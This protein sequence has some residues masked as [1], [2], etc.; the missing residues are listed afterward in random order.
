MLY[1]AFFDISDPTLGLGQVIVGD[2]T[3]SNVIIEFATLLGFDADA[4]VTPKLMHSPIAE[5]SIQAQDGSAT[6]VS[7]KLSRQSFG[8]AFTTY[9]QVTALAN[10]WAGPEFLVAGIDATTGLYGVGYALGAVNISLTFSTAAGAAL[11]GFAFPLTS[12]APA[13]TGIAIPNYVIKP[14]QRAVSHPTPDRESGTVASFAI[15]DDGRHGYG[16]GR[17]GV[18]VERD[19][20]Q[21]WEPVAKVEPINAVSTHPWTHRHLFRH[22]GRKGLPFV[23]TDGGFGNSIPELFHLRGESTAFEAKYAYDMVTAFR[24]VVYGTYVFGGIVAT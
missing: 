4:V 7:R 23:V 10:G 1:Q 9:L 14:T 20:A 5:Y 6:E 2:G 19:W 3:H 8:R 22:C 13:H 11:M 15:S 16:H 18:A 24:N 17:E 12:G 21:Q